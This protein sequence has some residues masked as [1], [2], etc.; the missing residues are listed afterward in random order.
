MSELDR[1]LAAIGRQREAKMRRSDHP[2]FFAEEEEHDNGMRGTVDEDHHRDVSG[3]GEVMADERTPKESWALV[4]AHVA[5][6][7]YH[8]EM[9]GNPGGFFMIDSETYLWAARRIMELEAEVKRLKAGM[10]HHFVRK[11]RGRE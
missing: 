6:N 1:K 5:A 2:L 4:G 7:D 10:D 9:E 11:P 3:E 8:V